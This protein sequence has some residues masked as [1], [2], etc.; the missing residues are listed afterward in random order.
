MSESEILIFSSFNWFSTFGL[1]D[2]SNFYTALGL[3]LYSRFK[4]VAI[5]INIYCNTLIQLNVSLN[6]NL[7]RLN[8]ILISAKC[9]QTD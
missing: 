2:A 4:Y 5:C 9:A 7:E 1:R 8:C 6:L 3:F